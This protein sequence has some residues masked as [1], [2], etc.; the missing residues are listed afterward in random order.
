MLGLVPRPAWIAPR[1]AI[2]DRG[3]SQKYMNT[4]EN[5]SFRSY[6]FPG[7]FKLYPGSGRFLVKVIA[8]AI[9]VAILVSQILIPA[10]V[11][12]SF[13]QT[14]EVSLSNSFNS[15]SVSEYKD[16][17]PFKTM[18]DVIRLLERD[19]RKVERDFL[20]NKLIS[21]LMGSAFFVTLLLASSLTV[22]ILEVTDP[23]KK[24]KG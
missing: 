22:L 15:P 17:E 20:L 23:P 10:F 5:T 19:L 7:I 9:P 24:R 4:E 16:T 14:T 3:R 1:L 13:E 6:W 8:A 21:D 11:K 2:G 18:Q 12:P